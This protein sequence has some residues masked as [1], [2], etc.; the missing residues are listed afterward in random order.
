M[1]NYVRVRCA[2]MCVYV[3]VCVSLYMWVHAL[4]E[5]MCVCVCSVTVCMCG[6]AFHQNKTHIKPSMKTKLILTS[7]HP[8]NSIYP[9]KFSCTSIST[10]RQSESLIL[11]VKCAVQWTGIKKS[12]PRHRRTA[13]CV[14]Q[15][16]IRIC[17]THFI[18][19]RNFEIAP[20]K[21]EI[22]NLCNYL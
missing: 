16:H 19:L 21:L 13:K 9:Q 3:G 1:F 18:N 20:R 12:L 2:C 7:S 5:Y 22:F 6:S 11:G 4:K 17:S 10:W 15:Q 14:F 8:Q